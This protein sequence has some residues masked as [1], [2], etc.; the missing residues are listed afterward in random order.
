MK[1]SLIGFIIRLVLLTIFSFGVHYSVLNWGLE[2]SGMYYSL[3][4]IY[5]YLFSL[6]LLIYLGLYYLSKFLKDYVGMG[7]LIG[8]VIKM[9][10]SFLLFIP[11]INLDGYN[12]LADILNFFIPY[13]IFLIFETI[14]AIS[15]INKK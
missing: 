2:V 12:Y 4:I 10:A 9:L 1:N 13:F 3:W 5:V 6:T 7:F 14:G 8:V 15:L 11:L